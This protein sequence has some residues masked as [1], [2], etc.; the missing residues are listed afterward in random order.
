MRTQN[1]TASLFSSKS[2]KSIISISSTLS[3]A[4]I[5][6]EAERAAL[7]AKAA[8]LKHKHTLEEEQEKFHQKREE[9]R[10][11]SVTLHI[12]TE[13]AA[14]TVKIN[15][16]KDVDMSAKGNIVYND[17]DGTNAYFNEMENMEFYSTGENAPV[18]RL[19]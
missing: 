4:H 15:Y 6:A 3:S 13:I 19:K 8:G 1:M 14:T 9:I 7:L 12:Q 16:L 18:T 2:G 5:N 11:R 17:P 10:K